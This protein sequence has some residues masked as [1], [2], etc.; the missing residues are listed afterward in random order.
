MRLRYFQCMRNVSD[1]HMGFIKSKCICPLMPVQ[2]FLNVTT[3]THSLKWRNLYKFYLKYTEKYC[4]FV[5]G[6]RDRSLTIRYCEGMTDKHYFSL[7][8][9]WPWNGLKHIVI[10]V[11]TSNYFIFL[12]YFLSKFFNTLIK[13]S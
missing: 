3:C 4:D 2:L 10:Y 1:V 12:I 11:S 9:A 6:R 8:V 13:F 7:I 5:K